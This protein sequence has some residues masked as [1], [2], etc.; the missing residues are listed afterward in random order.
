MNHTE[1]EINTVDPNQG[2]LVA[3]DRTKP[4]QTQP[5]SQ[6][7]QE[8]LLDGMTLAGA[9][10]ESGV[11]DFSDYATMMIDDLGSIITP[12]LLS[13]WE[14][15]RD[16]PGLD[17]SGMTDIHSSRMLYEKLLLKH[18]HGL[19]IQMVANTRLERQKYKD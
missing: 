14:S 19:S 16:Y 10:F 3:C 5:K 8:I 4:E 13:F 7:D 15:I 12:Y 2:G 18:E 9:Y 6:L 1:H 11:H 17:T